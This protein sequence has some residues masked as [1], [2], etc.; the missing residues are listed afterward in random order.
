MERIRPEGGQVIWEREGC[1][2]KFADFFSVKE[3]SVI[4][5]WGDAVTSGCEGPSAPHLKSRE[6]LLFLCQENGKEDTQ[7][8]EGEERRLTKRSLQCGGPIN[9]LY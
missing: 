8:E 2:D 7:G 1:K 5:V 4:T 3:K 9:A 6:E